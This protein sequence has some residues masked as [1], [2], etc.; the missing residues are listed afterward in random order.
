MVSTPAFWT[1]ASGSHLLMHRR[2]GGSSKENESRADFRASALENLSTCISISSLST[3][4]S[5]LPRTTPLALGHP[6]AL[7]KGLR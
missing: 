5:L 7:C 1:E 2:L 4:L 6:P 3:A